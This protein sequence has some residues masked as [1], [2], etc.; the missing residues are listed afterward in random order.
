[1]KKKAVVLSSGGLDSTTAMAMV[2]KEGFEIYSLSFDYGQRHRFELKAAA[3]VAKALEARTHLVIKLDLRK[4]GGSALTDRIDVPKS[5]KIT[6]MQK[7]IPVTYVP[8]RNTIFL[9]HALAWA[10]VS[11]ASDIVIGVN[12]VDYSGYPDCRPEYIEVF[13]RLANL[14][15]KAAVENRVQIKIQAPLLYLSKARIIKKGV[16]LGVDYSITH[17]CY[18]P[19]PRGISCGQC[20]SCILRLK[21][22]KA[23][24]IKDPVKYRKRA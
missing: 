1:M 9:S 17:S 19:S 23:A 18:D 11:G 14:A 20:D 6:D 15:T 8:A 3:R 5:R 24:G 16:A 7:E 22:F 4:I 21:G 10:E 13:E 2:K 12:A